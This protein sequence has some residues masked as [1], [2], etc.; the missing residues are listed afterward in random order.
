MKNVKLI[1]LSAILTSFLYQG[2]A[3]AQSGVLICNP[4][5]ASLAMPGILSARN[6]FDPFAWID[7]LKAKLNNCKRPVVAC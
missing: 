4:S 3:L 7:P 2:S 5:I 1:A 6:A